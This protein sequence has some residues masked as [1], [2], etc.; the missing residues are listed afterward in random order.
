MPG[1]VQSM[2]PRT[3]LEQ[4]TRFLDELPPW[5]AL[6]S[7]VV[8][9]FGVSMALS[10]LPPWGFAVGTVGITGLVGWLLL[11]G[12]P[13]VRV[14]WQPKPSEPE[15]APASL[16]TPTVTPKPNEHAHR[17]LNNE[18]LTMVELPGG[19]F[20]MGSPENEEGTDT[21]M[22]PGTGCGCQRSRWRSTQ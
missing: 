11:S 10:R 14:T 1:T 9:F 17:T 3:R 5:Q 16:P 6:G 4:T 2:K 7:G 15:P 19:E 22:K 12:K 13:L 20:W 8:V 18:L 21:T